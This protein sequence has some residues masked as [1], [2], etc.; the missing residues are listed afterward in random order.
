MSKEGPEMPK[1]KLTSAAVFE[2]PF[3]EK[4]Q[5]FVYDTVTRGFGVRVGTSK[6]SYIC[7]AQVNGK[8]R[9]VVIGD[10]SNLTTEEA[11]KAAKKYAGQMA[12]GVDP[13]AQKAEDRARVLTWDE[14]QE[15]FFKGRKIKETSLKNYKSVLRCQ[16]ADWGNKQLKDITPSMML[17]RFGAIGETSGPAT[18]N[19][20]GRIFRSVWNYCRAATANGA[21]EYVLPE[22]PVRRISETRSWH[23]EK[24]RQGY[25]RN[26][27]VPA[28]FDAVHGLVS[29]RHPS[30]AAAFRDLLE[31]Y[32]RTGLRRG[33]GMALAWKD[34]NLPG[35]LFTIAD[36][37][38]GKPLVLPMSNQLVTLFERRKEA[39]GG[40]GFVFAGEGA[41]GRLTDPRKMHDAVQASSGIAFGFHDLRRTFATLAERLDLSAYA[42]KRLLNHADNGD[43]TSGYLIAD[44]ERLREP[45]Q[46][47]SDELDR[48]AKLQK[49]AQIAA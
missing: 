13:N 43:V 36:T 5:A 46:R 42:I 7:E 28:W 15:A 49:V 17:K 40:K 32:I 8:T 20:A 35:R 14:A 31:L 6:K 10:T 16:F 33:E 24:R 34:V 3:A 21:G 29:E 4:G 30:H 27:Q 41:T 2:L 26:D 47:I 22:C 39:T 38:N 25:I 11:R 23:K 19:L 48:L 44:P 12:G 9:R 18:A 1:M 37:K 45:M